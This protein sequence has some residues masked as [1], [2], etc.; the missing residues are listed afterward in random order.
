AEHLRGR[1]RCLLRR[2]QVRR[3]E[4]ADRAAELSVW[5]LDA[6]RVA[7]PQP[8]VVELDEQLR[9][10]G[11]LAVTGVAGEAVAERARRLRVLL[12]LGA[13]R[14]EHGAQPLARDARLELLRQRIVLAGER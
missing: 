11:E 5:I 9:V 4:P 7:P 3:V 14:L 13:V 2:R 1:H 8:L 10:P 12:L 6:G